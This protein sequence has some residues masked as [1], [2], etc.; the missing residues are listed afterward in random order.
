MVAAGSL[1][2]FARDRVTLAIGSC[3]ALLGAMLGSL[4]PISDK[5]RV[6]LHL[7][8]A[9]TGLHGA[10][11]GWALI[12]CAVF[13]TRIVRRVDDVTLLRSA[14]VGMT[15]GLA[16]L[17][18]GHHVAVTLAAAA[19]LGTGA[20]TLVL[21][22]P[23]VLAVRHGADDRS[24]AFTFVNALGQTGSASTPIL[25]ALVLRVGW[26]WRWPLAIGAVVVGSIAIVNSRRTDLPRPV[27]VVADPPPVLSLLRRSSVAR[28]RWS[29][30]ALGVAV[31]FA[32][33]IWGSTSIQ[34]LGG[35]SAAMGSFG[36]GLFSVGMLVGRM[37][38]AGWLHRWNDVVVLRCSFT[39]A[40]AAML[41]LR[42]GPDVAARV[43]AMGAAGLAV[44]LIYP[45]AFARLYDA[46][47][48]D[49]SVGAVGA[50]A[51]GV[52]ITVSPPLLGVLAD[53]FDLGS[54]MFVVPAMC[55]AG[56]LLSG[57]GSTRTSNPAAWER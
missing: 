42:L 46:E 4:G 34:E 1:S 29:V 20:A 41:V 51:S 43:V 35:A 28:L 3:Y 17:S 56:F 47:L 45:V 49:V 5:L 8:G 33:L 7:S 36:V 12:V 32:A 48:P 52:A 14:L 10:L 38:G 19:L 9:V 53:L 54:A 26:G 24:A 57:A 13:A 16:A 40:G 39:V 2:S 6:E 21:S 22:A 27:Q 18:A 31:E 25:L 11:F 50:M 44:A 23:Q 37:F 15:I 55:A 30:V